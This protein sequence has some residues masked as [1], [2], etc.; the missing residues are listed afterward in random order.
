GPLA[1]GSLARTVGLLNPDGIL[2]VA[3]GLQPTT[4]L[5]IQKQKGAA[6]SLPVAQQCPVQPY[7]PYGANAPRAANAD[8]MTVRLATTTDGLNFTDMGPVNGLADSTTTSY[9]GTRYIAPNG[10]LIKVDA[11][12]YGLFFAGGNCMD[13]DSDAFHYIGYAESTDLMNWTIVN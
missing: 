9:V 7:A 5:Y 13:A 2:A 4:I 3:P 10:T 6:S 11:T 8:M 12:H 1:G